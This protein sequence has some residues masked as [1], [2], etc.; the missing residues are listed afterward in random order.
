VKL[1]VVGSRSIEKFD[2]SQYIPKDIDLII[3]GGASGIDSIAEFFADKHKISK[4]VLR[5]QYHIYKK[6]APLKRNEKMVNL[7]DE[8]LVIWDG[9]SKGA[10]YTMKYTER[11]NKPLTVVKLVLND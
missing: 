9:K 8:I 6:A 2:L 4:L 7:A 5:P 1:L 11:Q 3:T 10:E